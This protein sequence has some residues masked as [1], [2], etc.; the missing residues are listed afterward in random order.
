VSIDQTP[1]AESTTTTTQTGFSGAEFAENPE[2]RC[3]CLLLLDTSGSMQGAAISQLNEGLRTFQDQLNSD[4]LAAKRVEVAILTFGPPTWQTDFTEAVNFQPPTLHA[5]NSTPM[6]AAIRE[7]LH[8][9]EERKASYNAN[10]IVYYRP[11]VFLITDGAPDPSDDW[12]GAAQEVRTGET[13]GKFSFY[14]VGVEGADMETLTEIAPPNRGPVKLQ[15]LNF[16]ELFQW[17]SKSMRSV[18]TAVP[19]SR[20]ELD[21]PGWIS[22]QT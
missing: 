11:W 6:G 20:V 3:P 14:A 12:R 4:P 17:L 13:A 8:R 1:Y 2:P 18:S 10:G 22:A 16:R 7:G 19:G 9:L 15:G 5:A 21:A